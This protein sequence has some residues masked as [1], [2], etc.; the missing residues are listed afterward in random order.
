MSWSRPGGRTR[1]CRSRNRTACG[2]PRSNSGGSS[3]APPPPLQGSAT[4][5]SSLLQTLRG[6]E[7]PSS[8]SSCSTATTAARSSWLISMRLI[9]A[10]AISGLVGPPTL[11]TKSPCRAC[12]AVD[13]LGTRRGAASTTRTLGGQ[14]KCVLSF[15]TLLCYTGEQQTCVDTCRYC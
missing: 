14:T 6:Y 12:S 4:R 5:W 3:R 1:R 11:A 2:G 10:A 9:A 13:A 15:E 7:A 8:N